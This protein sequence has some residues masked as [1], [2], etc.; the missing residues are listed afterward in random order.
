MQLITSMINLKRCNLSLLVFFI[1]TLGLHPLFGQQARGIVYEDT[2]KNQVRDQNEQGIPD[3]S[4]SNG[5]DVTRTDENGKYVLPASDDQ[6]IFVVKPAGYQFA[7][8]E[9]QQPQ[10]YY[11]HK[12]EGSPHTRFSGVSPTGPLPESVDFGLRPQMEEDQYSL[13]IFGDPQP[14]TLEEVHY[15]NKGVVSELVGN[16][17]HSFGIS[18]GDLVGDDLTLFYPYLHAVSRVGL[19]W[20]HV[21]GNHDM[22]FDAKEDQYADETF[23]AVFGP[24]NYS[25]NYG[26]VHYIVLD[27]VLYPDPRDAR[28][29]W[30]GFRKDQI[31]F[32]KNDLRHVPNDHL[33]IVSFHIPITDFG[34]GDQFKDEDR[35]K[36]FD[37][38]KDYPNTLSLSAHTH[39]QMHDFFGKDRGWRGNKVHHHYNVGTTS[40]DWYS[41]TMDNNGTPNSRMRDGTPK[42]YAVINIDGNK[43]TFDYRVSGGEQTDKMYIHTPKVVS[44]KGRSRGEVVVNFYQGSHRDSLF[45]RVDEGDWQAMRYAP[46]Y[47]PVILK[48]HHEWDYQ[49]YPPEEK[50]PSLPINSTHIW[51]ARIPN[52]LGSGKHTIEVKAKDFLGRNYTEKTSY[53]IR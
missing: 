41:G 4:V 12:P 15:F 34:G 26:K 11:I 23:E 5:V 51:R 18:L 9:Y 24:A 36:L 17:E 28:G 42:G 48:A 30:G 22:N 7:L 29:Y 46:S 20:Y 53:I 39:F 14:Y 6:I 3:V 45:F 38:L 35:D 1:L 52:H 44:G 43:Y 33:I 16:K 40:G 19:P 37:L 25:F 8:N 27:D 32:I 50:R 21:Y 47:D 13:V 31:E 10:F 49:Y 2:N